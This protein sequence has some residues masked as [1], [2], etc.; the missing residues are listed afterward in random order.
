[1]NIIRRCLAV[2]VVA[3]ATFA[4]TSVFSTSNTFALEAEDSLHSA[5]LT[6]DND[7]IDVYNNIFYNT[8]NKEVYGEVP[9]KDLVTTAAGGTMV[10]DF[11]ISDVV[12]RLNRKSK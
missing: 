1:M 5:I 7:V 8:A 6:Y 12:L 2:A 10:V 3:L 4:L 9:I 11:I